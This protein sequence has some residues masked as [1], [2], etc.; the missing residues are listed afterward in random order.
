MNKLFKERE[1]IGFSAFSVLGLFGPLKELNFSRVAQEP[2]PNFL[3]FQN[4]FK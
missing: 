2:K 3:V 4:V 1:K